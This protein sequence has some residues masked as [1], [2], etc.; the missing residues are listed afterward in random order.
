MRRGIQGRQVERIQ[1]RKKI[2]EA[3]NMSP[4]RQWQLCEKLHAQMI[5]GL[6]TMRGKERHQ[7]SHPKPVLLAI[8]VI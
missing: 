2:L 3:I 8:Q 4:S 5:Y 1:G 6:L 7:R